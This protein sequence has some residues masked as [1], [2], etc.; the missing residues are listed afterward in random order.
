MQRL[1]SALQPKPA[2]W[3]AKHTAGHVKS[4]LTCQCNFALNQRS[5]EPNHDQ[6]PYAASSS[7]HSARQHE[8]SEPMAQTWNW[9]SVLQVAW[10]H[11]I[12]AER[13]LPVHAGQRRQ[14][15]RPSTPSSGSSESLKAR[16]RETGPFFEELNH[17]AEG[18]PDLN[19]PFF[20][21][22]WLRLRPYALRSRGSRLLL[23]WAIHTPQIGLPEALT[24]CASGA[25]SMTGYEA[26]WRKALPG[27]SQGG[28]RLV[29]LRLLCRSI[30]TLICGGAGHD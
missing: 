13:C 23:E 4:P 12:Y 20:A 27:P 2:Y 9:T 24:S 19:Q 22:T 11:S 10:A 28:V 29:A 8:H 6:L 14:Y 5:A 7:K 25:L 17:R 30:K 21:C 15:N 1:I 18:T 26:S 16:G 3:D